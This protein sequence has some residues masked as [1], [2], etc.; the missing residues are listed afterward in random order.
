MEENLIEDELF[1]E[2]LELGEKYKK[3]K[4]LLLLCFLYF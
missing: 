4:K 3:I 1:E 2:Y